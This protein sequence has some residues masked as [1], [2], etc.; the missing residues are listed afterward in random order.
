MDTLKD[1]F[2]DASAE[3]ELETN[4]VE[5][6]VEAIHEDA[7]EELE[8]APVEEA[9]PATEAEAEPETVKPTMVPVAALTA[10]RAKAREDRDEVARLRQQIAQMQPAKVAEAQNTPIE[11]PD[12]YDDPTGY[13][14]WQQQHIAAQVE[15]QIFIRNLEASKAR[16]LKEHGSDFVNEVAAWAGEEADRNPIFE[17][18]LMRQA[19]PAA[20][21]IEAKKRSDLIKSF[22]ADPDAYVRAR[23]AELGLA[24]IATT[25]AAAP[26]P[27]VRKP[28][29]SIAAAKSRDLAQSA[30]TQQDIF[31]SVF[32]K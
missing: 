21:V 9:E 3:T 30:T 6:E 20:W 27:T 26:Q 5:N 4:E 8:A 11:H 14:Q 10:E 29:Q 28:V 22:E 19:D 13:V 16:A 23:A 15:Q 31:D 18:E 7:P 24:D 1:F 2:E 17:V 12:P 25:V 32:K